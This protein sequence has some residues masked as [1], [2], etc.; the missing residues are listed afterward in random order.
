VPIPCFLLFLCF[1]KV[2]QEIFSE[3]DETK[4][5]PPIIKW[6]FQKTE[7]ET[8]RGHGLATPQGGAAQPLAAPTHGESA[9]VHL[10]RSPLAY[11][12]PPMGKT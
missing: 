1:R 11:K 8:K 5:E 2:T 6:I 12:D 4:A 9:M 7:E 3:L 10:W